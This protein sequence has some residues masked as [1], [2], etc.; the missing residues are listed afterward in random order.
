VSVQCQ[1][2]E[3]SGGPC[4]WEGPLPETVEVEF[5]RCSGQEPVRLRVHDECA[6]VMTREDGDRIRVIETETLDPA[7]AG[8]GGAL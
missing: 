3:W 4:P 7:L 6:M 8:R 1:C 2:G 5:T